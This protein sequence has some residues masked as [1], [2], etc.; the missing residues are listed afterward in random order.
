MHDK[1]FG[2]TFPICP[3][4]ELKVELTVNKHK[5][6]M[7]TALLVL[8][9]IQGHTVINSHPMPCMVES[10]YSWMHDVQFGC[11]LSIRLENELKFELEMNKH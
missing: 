9:N 5:C 2:C 8:C 4:N 10:Y 11:T 6:T 7:L 1:Q 3:A